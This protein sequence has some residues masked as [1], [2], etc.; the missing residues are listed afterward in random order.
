ME[1]KEI[2]KRIKKDKVEI[3][4]LQ[5][6]DLHGEIKEVI[7]PSDKLS[8]SLKKGI[9]FDGSSIEGFTRISESDLFLKPDISTYSIL[10]WYRNDTKEARII[11]DIYTSKGDLC[12]TGP[13]SVLKKNIKELKKKGFEYYVGAEIEFYL[14]KDVDKYF[15]FSFLDT[16]S[17]F[18]LST[19]EGDEFLSQIIKSLKAF[20][21]SV[22]AA[23]HEVGNS[24]F[25]IDFQY[26][27]AERISDK[28]LTLK[29]V[30]RYVAREMGLRVTFMPKPI[31]NFAGS[32]MHVHQSLFKKGKNVFFDKKDAYNLSKIA[33]NFIAG[34]MANIKGMCAVL[35]P[36][37]NSYKR[38]VP[39]YEAPVYISWARTN[40]STLIRIPEWS[41]TSE[42][43]ARFEIRN[44]DVSANPYLA[45]SVL[46]QAGLEGLRK[47]L[48]PPKPIEK[49][50]FTFDEADLDY[51]KIGTLP[52][53]LFEAINEFKKN[54]LMKKAFGEILFKKYIEI[55]EKEWNQFK[56]Q[57]TKW[58]L[59]K[60]FDK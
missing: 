5:F 22:E 46:A 47:K 10:P 37:I 6:S 13:R 12:E 7:I 25:E 19:R 23:H 17:Y 36:N 50:L 53:S 29:Y 28:I 38:L 30:I 43:S 11:C 26:D 49:N 41:K 39:G 24:Q 2:L 57:V 8:D 55:K 44:P 16:F 32:G 40:R 33:Y 20:D 27:R 59:N 15:N 3:L 1:Q 9:W 34:Q 4:H 60:Y 18:D 51:H 58:E 31:M 45:F 48:I 14:F 21:I 52:G 56:I 35:N 54:T 42:S